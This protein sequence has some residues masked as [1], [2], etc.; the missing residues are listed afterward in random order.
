MM[1]SKKIKKLEKINRNSAARFKKNGLK[2]PRVQTGLIDRPP[3]LF[4]QS[5]VHLLESDVF[6]G[7]KND[8][9]FFDISMINMFKFITSVEV[10]KDV[11]E[12]LVTVLLES[13]QTF[14]LEQTKNVVDELEKNESPAV[15]SW[16]DSLRVFDQKYHAF[17]DEFEAL[18]KET[19]MQKKFLLYKMRQQVAA[20]RLYLLSTYPAFE[21]RYRMRADQVKLTELCLNETFLKEMGYT[22]QNFSSTVLSEGL[23]QFFAVAPLPHVMNSMKL[24]LENYMVNESEVAEHE[25]E[26]FM[27]TG[28]KKKATV[29][30]IT[31]VEL[32]EGDLILSYVVYIKTKS[33]P[34]GSYQKLPYSPDF[35][36]ILK[37]RDNE[38]EYLFSTYYGENIQGL[39]SN[40]E[41]VCKIKEISML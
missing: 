16:V 31:L 33:L 40:T 2:P 17:I 4:D 27:K 1:E 11:S 26:L 5:Q 13:K 8:E 14:P 23:P 18:K 41:K 3:R 39:H 25:C 22:M 6:F 37:E 10:R 30:A 15:Q 29:Q 12:K 28:Y 38:K 7:I 24:F 34:F 21:M 35:L 20:K 36:E 19:N 9:I 32:S